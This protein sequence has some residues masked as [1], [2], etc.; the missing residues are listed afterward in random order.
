VDEAFLELTRQM[1]QYYGGPEAK[2]AEKGRK[3]LC[4]I[5]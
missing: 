5:L 1:I 3:R 2:K 4:T